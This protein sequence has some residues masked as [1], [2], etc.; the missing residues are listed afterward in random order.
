MSKSHR[1]AL[2]AGAMA[3][4]AVASAPAMGGERYG[5]GQTA[6]PELIAGW[7]IDVRPDGQG[8][9]TGQGTAA[10]GEA[11]FVEQCASCHGEFGEAVGRFPVLIGGGDSLA[12]STPVKTVG[13]YWPYASTLWDY[14]HRA[15]PFGNAQSLSVD[16]TYAV[17]AYVLYLNDLVAEDFVLD[18]SSLPKVAMPNR[19]GFIAEDPRPDTSV[20]EPCVSN[21]KAEAKVMFKAKRLDVTPERESD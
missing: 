8:L 7:D 16:E 18:R 14:I 6:S 12:S 17:T 4:V 20:D 2:F 19:D 3:L 13:S 21:C 1:A 9:P 10:D 11:V 15:M 5:L